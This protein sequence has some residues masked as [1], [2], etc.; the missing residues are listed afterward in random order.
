VADKLALLPDVGTGLERLVPEVNTLARPES[1]PLIA[2]RFEVQRNLAIKTVFAQARREQW[3]ADKLAEAVTPLLGVVLEAPAAQVAQVARYLADEY[4][5]IGDSVLVCSSSTGKAF[6]KIH[7]EDIIQPRP[8]PRENTDKLAQPLPRIRPDLHGFLVQ[9]V[10]DEER[11]KVL[12]AALAERHH[13]TAL[14]RE[15]GDSR[16]LPITRSGRAELTQRL[17]DALPTLLRADHGPGRVF[18]SCFD[19]LDEPPNDSALWPVE[20]CSAT[21]GTV[22]SIADLKSFNLKYDREV[23]RLAQVRGG[24]ARDIA[25]TLALEAQKH[26]AV[27][28][29]I[30]WGTEFPIRD[31]LALPHETWIGPPEFTQALVA[32]G[33]LEVFHMVVAGAPVTGL[34]GKVGAIVLKGSDCKSREIF[35]RWETAARIEYELWVDWFRVASLKFID[36]PQPEVIV[37]VVR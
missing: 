23:A 24:W 28:A 12:T 3:P 7:D 29:T 31:I 4:E 11:E 15:E 26:A 16:L 35:D 6:A 18:L 27:K 30:K 34:Q 13:Q 25:M 37:E 10:F 20:Q 1:G 5:Q 14:Q 33:S 19:I 2:A 22:A 8:V 17:K 21:Y 36:M 32:S 9:W